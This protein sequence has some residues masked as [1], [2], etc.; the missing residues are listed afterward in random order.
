MEENICLVI[1]KFFLQQKGILSQ[2][3]CPSIPL[4][5]GVAKRKNRHLLDVVR[6]LLLEF[7]IPPRFW[8]EALSI[9]VHL[10][11]RLPAQHLDFDS[12][13]YRLHDTHP[14]YDILY[15]FGCVYFIQLPPQESPK[16]AVESVRCAFMGYSMAH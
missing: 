6:V 3:S 9:A 1:V 15:I 13:H 4:Q 2:H 16:L 10:I 8:V 14:S 11:N 7:S 12:P 5:N